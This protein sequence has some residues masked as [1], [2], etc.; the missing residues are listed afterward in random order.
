MSDSAKGSIIRSNNRAFLAIIG[1]LMTFCAICAPASAKNNVTVYSGGTIITMDGDT[2]EMVEAVAVRNGRIIAVGTQREIDAKAGH[3]PTVVDLKGSTM[4]PGFIDAHGHVSSFGQT[5][6][7][8]NL[9][10]PPLGTVD[11]IA[12]LQAALRAYEKQADL[13]PGVPI[14]GTGY[15][16]SQLVERQHPTRADLDE[17]SSERPILISHASG[18][19]A[20][21]NSAMLKMA[22]ITAD[23][24]DP[25]GG[26]IRREA[27]G[28]TPNGVLEENA[29][30]NNMAMFTP[31]DPQAAVKTLLHG[32]NL[33]A[34]FGVTTAQDGR[35]YPMFW[36]PFDVAATAEKLPLDTAV[37]IAGDAKWPEEIQKRIG[38][39]YKN[40][41]RIAGIKLSLDGSPQGRTAWLKDPVPVPPDGADKDYHGYP[42]FKESE[43][44]PILK[45]AAENDWQVFAHVNGD[46]A[47]EQLIAGV[48]VNGLAGK[49]TI[50]IHNQVTTKEQLRKM[51]E[52][53]IH[54]SFFVS[55]TYFWG[56]WHRDV[57]LGSKRA[58][59]ISPLATALA[60][61][62]R[63]TIHNDSPVTPPNMMR[64]VWTAVN[65]RT[66]SGDI[67]G[68]LERVSP[69]DAL[70]MIT[71]N[72]A[73][74]L[75]LDD[76]I[77][78]IEVGKLADFTVLDRDWL[79]VPEADILTSENLMTIVGG[80]VT[81]QK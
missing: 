67:L 80:R 40:R 20:V 18:H 25:Q 17:V 36:P 24:K 30:F 22:K 64:L 59:F 55:H 71:I 34:G 63:P 32:E 43:L 39:G 79:T 12:K 29:F 54:P 57:A 33:Y 42:S 49:R 78:S 1:L 3:S 31:S 28:K 56:D 26:T 44:Y 51:K 46:A 75:G 5:S 13:P 41:L 7:L 15:D 72:A 8:A 50:A 45:E 70:K 35:I 9:A 47:A 60:V 81:Y 16:D 14:I 65:R 53:D 58:D 76:K 19:L 2:P 10:A 4:L 73:W 38:N 37:L 6:N 74:S 21:M 11:S 66:Q 77:G 68:P 62:L 23:S 61:G 69:Y 27:D 52:L 48:R